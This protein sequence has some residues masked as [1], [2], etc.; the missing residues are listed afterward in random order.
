MWFTKW[1]CIGEYLMIVSMLLPKKK[2]MRMPKIATALILLF[3]IESKAYND[4]GVDECWEQESCKT[5][6]VTE[7]DGAMGTAIVGG[8]LFGL[9][10]AV[11]GTS[12]GRTCVTSPKNICTVQCLCINHGE[13][14]VYNQYSRYC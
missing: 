3:S 13:I 5:V 10:G 8:L 4:P 12:V 7:C 6:Q 2:K 1:I 14:T 11:I 9:A